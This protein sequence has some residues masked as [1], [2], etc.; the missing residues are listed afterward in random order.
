[1]T[2]QSISHNVFALTTY[3]GRAGCPLDIF[4]ALIKGQQEAGKR[5]EWNVTEPDVH[6]IGDTAWIAYV[7]KGSITGSSGTVDQ[8]WLESAFLQ[9]QEGTWKILFTHST[10][11]SKPVNTTNPNKI[12]AVNVA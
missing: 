6:I 1:M 9:K 8:Q 11:V 3:Q 12:E 5:H 2:T 4:G 10:R 7:N